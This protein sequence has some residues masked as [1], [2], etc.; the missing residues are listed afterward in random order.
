VDQLLA[1]ALGHSEL[2]AEMLPSLAFHAHYIER[3]LSTYFSPNTHLIGEAVALVFYR[4]S[5]SPVR[6]GGAVA[7]RRV[8]NR[9]E[10]RHSADSTRRRLL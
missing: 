7:I 6:D 1:G 3:Y 9:T 5:V 4:D 8:E 2:H 10:R